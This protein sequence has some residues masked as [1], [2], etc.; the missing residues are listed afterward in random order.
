MRNRCGLAAMATAV[1]STAA[2]AA[3]APPSPA[4][5]YNRVY[6]DGRVQ[7]KACSADDKRQIAQSIDQLARSTGATAA[8]PTIRFEDGWPP[9]ILQDCPATIA[10][11]AEAR[12]VIFIAAPPPLAEPAR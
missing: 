7:D 11:T 9:E 6:V 3:T 10:A 8:E 5:G 1:F 12:H 2:W 4:N